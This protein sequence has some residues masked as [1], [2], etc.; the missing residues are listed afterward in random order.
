MEKFAK[1]N[2]SVLFIAAGV[3]VALLA[4]I[5][6][7]VYYQNRINTLNA[8]VAKRDMKTEYKTGDELRADFYNVETASLVSPHTMRLK[9]DSGEVDFVLI[10]VRAAADYEKG[11]IR[12][13]I[14][15]PFDGSEEAIDKVR[16]ALQDGKKERRGY[17]IIYCYSYAC[18]LGAKTGKELSAHGISVKE[19]SVGY[20]D[21][22]LQHKVWNNPGE[23]YDINDYIV[24]GDQPGELR[25]SAAYLNRPCSETEEFS[26]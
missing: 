6:S 19:L 23:V 15:I 14:N 24:T 11:H 13:A 25:P 22:E 18:M 9:M 16:Q 5:G 10:D 20:N 21:W 26:C 12:G 8:E 17:G 4:Q 2:R 7:A 3:I 1:T